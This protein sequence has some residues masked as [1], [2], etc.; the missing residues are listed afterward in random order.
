MPSEQ[1]QVSL[2]PLIKPGPLRPRFVIK[3]LAGTVL[4]KVGV[5][6]YH[7]DNA[8]H[9]ANTAFENNTQPLQLGRFLAMRQLGGG[10]LRVLLAS[11][12][13]DDLTALLKKTNTSFPDEIRIEDDEEERFDLCIDIEKTQLSRRSDVLSAGQ[14]LHAQLEGSSRHLY[15]VTPLELKGHNETRIIKRLKD[16]NE[17]LA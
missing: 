13:H 8:I 5:A 3:T 9:T 10:A 12:N 7:Y 4:D 2:E 17:A 1:L 14:Q 16:T 11:N 6:N 15:S